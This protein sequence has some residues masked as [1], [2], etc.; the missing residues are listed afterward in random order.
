MARIRSISEGLQAIRPHDSEVDCFYN[1]VQ[2]ADGDRLLHLSTFGSDNRQ[3]KPKSSQSIQI[4]EEMAKVLVQL[5]KT[6]FPNL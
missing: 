6:T 2:T 3:S 1:V 4:D 5:L